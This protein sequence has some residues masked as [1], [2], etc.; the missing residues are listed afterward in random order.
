MFGGGAATEGDGIQV[1]LK[2]EQ[3]AQKI[4]GD[5]RKGASARGQGC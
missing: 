4:V 2:A 3:E 5:A 1:L